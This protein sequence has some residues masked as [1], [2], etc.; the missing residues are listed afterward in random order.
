MTDLPEPT[1]ADTAPR[2]EPRWPMVQAFF[3]HLTGKAPDLNGMLFLIGVQ[4]LGQGSRAFSKEEKQD[5]M[6]L[7]IC[8]ILAP[9]GHWEPLGPDAEGWPHFAPGVPMPM[10]ALPDQETYLMTALADYLAALGLLGP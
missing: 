2:P 3:E 7:G 5:L 9:L 1:D 4:E 10:L 6:H 8:T